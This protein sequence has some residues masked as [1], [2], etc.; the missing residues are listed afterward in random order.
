MHSF[1]AGST[2]RREQ[3]CTKTTTSLHEIAAAAINGTP[4]THP[5]I[6]PP[7]H[8]PTPQSNH[9]VWSQLFPSTL[10]PSTST[11]FWYPLRLVCLCKACGAAGRPDL[12]LRCL[13]EMNIDQAPGRVSRAYISCLSH[14]AV[15]C[16]C[17][18]VCVLF[19]F[20][21]KW[22]VLSQK[23]AATG[24]ECGEIKVFGHGKSM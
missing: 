7:T 10:H 20:A 11:C 23:G 1:A 15:L 14:L 24:G 8:P 5:H 9:A 3:T 4:S 22:N 13:A 2:S 16:V 6:H 19:F 12:V 18:C 21:M 17:A